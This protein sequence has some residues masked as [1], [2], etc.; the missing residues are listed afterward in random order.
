MNARFSCFLVKR[1]TFF[2]ELHGNIRMYLCIIK[3][4]YQYFCKNV[5]CAKFYF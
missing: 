3:D 5:M 4:E 1:D 2:L